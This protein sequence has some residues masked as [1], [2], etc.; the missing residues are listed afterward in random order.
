LFS[1]LTLVDLMFVD[2]ERIEPRL[3]YELL[4]SAVLPRPIAWVSTRSLSGV[5]NLAPFSFFNLFSTSPAILGFSP[6]LKR[7]SASS[8]LVMKDSLR[9]VLES[10]EFVV[11]IVNLKMAAKMVQSSAN[12]APEQSEFVEAELRSLPSEQVNVARLADAP[13]SL[14]CKLHKIVELGS[15]SLVLGRIVCMHV[16][17]SVL[18]DGKID[19]VKLQP[20]ARLGGDL[21][22][23]LSEPFEIARPD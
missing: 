22:A 12:Y 10:G 19:V 20:L 4:V 8:E 17:D 2:L 23:T 16:D 15:N 7:V 11:N 14:E 9:N 6:G 3:R 13:L 18:S 5:D 1:Q 21:Y